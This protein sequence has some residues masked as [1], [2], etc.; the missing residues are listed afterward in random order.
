[1]ITFIYEAYAKDGS[2]VRGEHESG[3]RQDVI[4]YLSKHNLTP[5]SIKRLH[6]VGGKRGLLS[7]QFFDSIKPVDIMFFVRN[8]ATTT[9][10][11]LSVVESLD[12]L[13]E[14]TEKVSMKKILQGAQAMI[15]NGRLLSDGFE[16]HANSFPPIFMG[17]LRAGEISGQLDATLAELGKYLS[18]EYELRS[19]IKSALMYPAILLISSLCVVILLLMF[20]LP[21]LTKAFL[22]SGAELPFAT[23]FFLAISNAL[24]Y[25]FI[26]DFVLLF[27]FVW[28]F[29][30]FRTTI[31]GKKFFFWLLSHTPVASSLIKKVALVRF[32]RTFGNLIASGLS[33]VES[34]ELSSRSIGNRSYMLAIE[35]AVEDI[36]NGVSMS[37]SFAK[38]PEL[39][40]KMLI[41]LIAVGERTGSLQSIL[42]TFADFYEEEVDTSLKD[43]T[44]ILEP[45]LL[46]VMGFLVGSIAFSIILPIYQLVGNFV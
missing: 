2:I 9:K 20:V 24:T 16:S 33:A 32:S 30:Y 39:F 35:K 42:I 46:L 31:L 5:I 19:K 26:L 28:F 3:E 40:P 17:M 23:K 34:L 11:G 8:L 25:S 13:I 21:K 6:S 10:A 36:K 7:M 38:Y 15:K 29:L 27:G 44:S 37:E 41:S 43:L 1:M 4:E 45:A 22:T 12:I 14:D 18:K